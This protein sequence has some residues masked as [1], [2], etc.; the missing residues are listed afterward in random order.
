M[1]DEDATY[2]D[3][4]HEDFDALLE[5]LFGFALQMLGEH[6]EF[7]PAG[8]AVTADGEVQLVAVDADDDQPEV[9]EVVD[10]LAERLGEMA[11]AGEIRASGIVVNVVLELEGRDEPA[12]AALVHL[13]HR[14]GE[15]LDVALPYEPHG[16]HVHTGDLIAAPGTAR[17]FSASA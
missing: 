9:T 14:E 7:F 2:E 6:G 12:D 11:A 8:A 13:E 10:L 15:P 3:A 5:P 17:V 4:A 16:D 1:S